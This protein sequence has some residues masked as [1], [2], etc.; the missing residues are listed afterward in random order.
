MV[1]TNYEMLIPLLWSK[2][3]KCWKE[4][5]KNQRSGKLE[6]RWK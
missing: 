4:H 5:N 1:R 2:I 3:T 6:M